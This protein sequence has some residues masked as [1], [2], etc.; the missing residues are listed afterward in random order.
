MASL[1]RRKC[2]VCGTLIK[3]YYIPGTWWLACCSKKCYEEFDAKR[4]EL[5]GVLKALGWFA[6]RE[7][8]A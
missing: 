3:C 5:G 8:S 1:A 6:R 7:Q 2:P 4:K